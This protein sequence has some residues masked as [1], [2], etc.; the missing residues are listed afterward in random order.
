M[1]LRVIATGLLLLLATSALAQSPLNDVQFKWGN[2]QQNGFQRKTTPEIDRYDSLA[3]NVDKQKF[4]TDAGAQLGIGTESPSNL[5]TELTILSS[6]LKQVGA[7][8]AAL[9]NTV[10]SVAK[11]NAANPGTQMSMVEAM[12][13]DPQLAQARAGFRSGLADMKKLKTIDPQTY[14]AVEQSFGSSSAYVSAANA[15]EDRLNQLSATLQQSATATGA[16]GLTA[17]IVPPD[18]AA[19]ALHLPNYDQNAVSSTV[20]VPNYIPVVDAR[21]QREITAAEDFRDV[22]KSLTQVSSQFQ[23]SMKELQTSLDTLRTSLKTEVLEVQLNSLIQQVRSS[24]RTDLGPVLTDAI[25]ARD[26]VQ[27]LNSTTLTIDGTT[28]AQRLLNVANSMSTTAQTLLDASKGI[29]DDLNKLANDTET[30]VKTTA[31]ATLSQSEAMVK[32]AASDFIAKQTFF[33]TL[34]N[35]LMSLGQLL[36]ADS[37]VALSADRL[38]ATARNLDTTLDLR[39]IPGDVHVRDNIVVQAALYRRDSTGQLTQ[40]STDSQAF[41]IQRYDIFPDSVRGGLIFAEP[42][43]KIDRDISY[44]PVPALGYYWRTGIHGHPTWNAISP[45]FGFTMALLDFSDTNTMEIGFAGG[46]SIL[47]DLAW[48]G[49]GRNLQAKANYFYVGTNPLL[50][51]KLFQ[52]GGLR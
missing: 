35:Q 25:A 40:V 10:A 20:A 29:P 37:R 5:E 19:R 2:S 18:A 43:S 14:A 31:D 51:V 26:L 41:V 32:Q 13:G 34:A 50:L 1:R 49:Y 7:Y 8:H 28:D 48:V 23:A 36:A 6:F 12:A 42:R 3:I 47:R 38:A 24:A 21:T 15:I 16:L 27:Q 11:Q 4:L 45:S 9:L 46:V 17:T 39:T 22:A 44:Q 52:N 33:T 30:A